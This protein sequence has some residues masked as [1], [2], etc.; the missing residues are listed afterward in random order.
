M[1]RI[2]NSTNV[3][4]VCNEYKLHL[5]NNAKMEDD[6]CMI[7]VSGAVIKYRQTPMQFAVTGLIRFL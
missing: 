5:A 6:R 2:T 4:Y 7:F 1:S 3:V